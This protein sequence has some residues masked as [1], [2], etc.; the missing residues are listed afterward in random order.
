MTEKH[1]ADDV[2]PKP[3]Y[4]VEFAGRTW[5]LRF[6]LI[7]SAVIEKRHGSLKGFLMDFAEGEDGPFMTCLTTALLAG[8]AHAG[9]TETRLDE[10][11]SLKDLD[12]ITGPLVEAFW[13]AYDLPTADDL[14]N[15]GEVAD[16]DEP[17]GEAVAATSAA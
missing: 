3:S 14:D 6:G 1:P 2:L 8:L 16:G 11:V 9:V 15:N 4:E 17:V 13:D 5:K 10:L 7:A 12:T